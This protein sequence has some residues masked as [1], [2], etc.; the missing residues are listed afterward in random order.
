MLNGEIIPLAA[1]VKVGSKN[2]RTDHF[3]HGGI[4]LGV[5]LEGNVSSWGGVKWES[6]KGN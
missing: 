2:G 3:H 4:I 1:L 5:D 6:T